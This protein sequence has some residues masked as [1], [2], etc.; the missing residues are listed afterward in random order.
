MIRLAG[1]CAFSGTSRDAAARRCLRRLVTVAGNVRF[2]GI[3]D[4]GGLDLYA[5]NMQLFAGDSYLVVRTRMD[6]DALHLQLRANID[7]VDPDQSL[8]DVQT[9]EERV[10]GSIWPHRVADA[11]LAVLAAIALCLAVIGTYAVTSYAVA[12]Q[13]HEIGIRLAL[14][15][16]N[17][18]VGWLMMRRCVTPVLV[19]T[20]LGLGAGL[21]VARQLAQI[22]GTAGANGWAMSA[23]LPVVLAAAAIGACY[24]PVRRIVRRMSLTALLSATT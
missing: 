23:A 13:R 1:G 17:S 9:M 12:A 24:L 18:Q 3:E 11:V 19:G 8:F 5:P 2:S 6:P 22:I 4:D 21:V 16:S 7:R 20:L 14:G 10:N 15:S